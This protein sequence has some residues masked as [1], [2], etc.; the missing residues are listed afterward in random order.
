MGE[1]TV[2]N[3]LKLFGTVTLSDY[4]RSLPALKQLDKTYDK[5]IG[6]LVLQNQPFTFCYEFTKTG[7]IHYHFHIESSNVDD[8]IIVLLDLFKSSRKKINDKYHGLFGFCKIEKSLHISDVDN[9]LSKELNRTESLVKRLTTRK[10]I[11]DKFPVFFNSVLSRRVKC[12]KP[13]TIQQMAEYRT[14]ALD[15]IIPVQEP[16]DEFE[17]PFD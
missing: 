9:Y 10:D 7:N 14:E 13:I 15:E 6:C 12:M 1:P 4:I 11:F 5:V 16:V 2:S 8:D 17:N 3:P